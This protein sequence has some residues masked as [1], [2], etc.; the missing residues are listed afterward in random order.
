M[1]SVYSGVFL[2]QISVSICQ[3]NISLTAPPAPATGASGPKFPSPLHR[4]GHGARVAEESMPSSSTPGS[5]VASR[6]CRINRGSSEKP[7]SDIQRE[8]GILGTRD[9]VILECGPSNGES[10]F[11]GEAHMAESLSLLEPWNP[12]LCDNSCDFLLLILFQFK[13]LRVEDL[14]IAMKGV[15]YTSPESHKLTPVRKKRTHC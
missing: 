11:K 1:L 3:P 7:D 6:P 4:G 13:L 12:S 9:L 5:A 10:P 15:Y 2:Q 8:I 14:S